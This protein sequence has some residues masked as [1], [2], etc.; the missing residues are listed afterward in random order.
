MA[1]KALTLHDLERMRIPKRYL[2]SIMDKHQDKNLIVKLENYIKLYVDGGR[3]KGILFYGQSGVGKDYAAVS[4]L[5]RLKGIVTGLNGM[6]LSIEEITKQLFYETFDEDESML[7]RAKNVD[8]L[9]ISG[10]GGEPKG[11]DKYDRTLFELLKSRVDNLKTVIITFR[12]ETTEGIRG[13]DDGTVDLIKAACVPIHVDGKNMWEVERK[14][15]EE[16]IDG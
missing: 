1:K 2:N 14:A 11:L 8:V 16:A 3:S 7:D 13:Y 10:M 9:V 15:I 12:A 5:K 4:L 6:Y